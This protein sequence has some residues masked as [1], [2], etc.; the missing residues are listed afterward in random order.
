MPEAAKQAAEV[1]RD[2]PHICALSAARLECRIAVVRVKQ[3]KG[4]DRYRPRRKQ[5]ASRHRE[6]CHRRAPH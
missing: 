1:A 6:R 5:S 4:V 2:G 3:I